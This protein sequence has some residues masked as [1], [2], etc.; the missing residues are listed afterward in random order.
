MGGDLTVT[1]DGIGCGCEFTAT[2]RIIDLA[3]PNMSDGGLPQ[4]ISRVP[5]WMAARISGTGTTAVGSREIFPS[6]SEAALGAPQPNYPSTGADHLRVSGGALVRPGRASVNLNAVAEATRLRRSSVGDEVPGER[7][8][9]TEQRPRSL[10]VLAVRS[11]ENS[12]ASSCAFH[13]RRQFLRT[14]SSRSGP[15]L[16]SVLCRWDQAEDDALCRRVLALTLR[17]AGVRLS[18][19][20]CP[21]GATG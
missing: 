14:P 18:Y 5:S 11:L 9:L 17:M 1:S 3:V 7:P 15:C 20:Y 13:L 6:I 16:T 19:T 8:H 4:P 21:E 10:R 12:R 2:A